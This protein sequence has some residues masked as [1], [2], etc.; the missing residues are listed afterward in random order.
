MYSSCSSGR[1]GIDILSPPTRSDTRHPKPRANFDRA[2][3]AQRHSNGST[4]GTTA[5]SGSVAIKQEDQGG[6][7]S[8]PWGT[9]GKVTK[10]DEWWRKP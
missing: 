10:G 2:G 6:E 7:E 1:F 9:A 4:A 5:R 3:S 8:N